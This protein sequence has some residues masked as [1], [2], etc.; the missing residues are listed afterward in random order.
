VLT[1]LPVSETS[2]PLKL[3]CEIAGEASGSV[4]CRSSDPKVAVSEPVQLVEAVPPTEQALTFANF[5]G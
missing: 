2:D 5:V 4:S 3:P 1:H